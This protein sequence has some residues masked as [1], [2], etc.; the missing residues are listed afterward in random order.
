MA[1]PGGTRRAAPGLYVSRRPLRVV[2]LDRESPLPG[3]ATA[4]YRRLPTAIG[5]PL[6]L[7]YAAAFVLFLPLMGFVTVARTLLR[8]GA[9]R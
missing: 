8:R 9:V 6:S 1:Y 7:A 4:R 2:A 5:L 3:P